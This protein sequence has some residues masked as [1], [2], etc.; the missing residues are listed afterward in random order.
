MSGWAIS[1]FIIIMFQRI[2]CFRATFAQYSDDG[3][4]DDD[5]ND[6]RQYDDDEKK[7][8]LSPGRRWRY[9]TERQRE[10]V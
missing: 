8:H 6:D 5:D 10:F 7:I 4:K 2:G 1:Y 9:K 3:N